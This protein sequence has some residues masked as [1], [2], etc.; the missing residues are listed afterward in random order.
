M[1]NGNVGIGVTAPTAK[2]EVKADTAD[3]S[4]A[5]V[6]MD[7]GD[8]ENFVV[9]DNGDVYSRGQ[10][11]LSQDVSTKGILFVGTGQTVDARTGFSN[12]GVGYRALQG[13]TA[14]SHSTGVGHSALLNASTGSANTAVGRSSFYT[15]TSMTG[16]IA[17]GAYAGYYETGNDKLF[18][19]SLTDAAQV[20]E[21]T[22][23][24]K[25]I[26]Y[27][28]QDGTT[29]ANQTLDLNAQVKATYGLQVGAGTTATAGLIQWDG[30]NFQ[31]YDGSGWVNLDT[32]GDASIWQDSGS[33]TTLVTPRAVQIDAPTAD[34]SAA[35]TI[36]DSGDN[37]NFVV[38]D[39]GQV[40]VGIAIPTEALDVVGNIR[41]S[42]GLLGG[43]VTTAIPLGDVSNTSL[44]IGS[45]FVG[46]INALSTNTLTNTTAISDIIS[47]L[48]T[49]QT[50]AGLNTDG[51]LPAWSS[52]NYLTATTLKAG[53]EELDAAMGS[54]AASTGVAGALQFSDGSGGLSADETNLFWDDTNDRLGIGV[55]IPLSTL[56]INGGVGTFDTGLMFGDGDTG[57]WEDIDDTLHLSI[58]NGASYVWDIT[59]GST[60]FS[61]N[62]NGPGIYHSS[63][64]A[65][66][67]VKF[68]PNWADVDTGI[69]WGG[70]EELVLLLMGEKLGKLQTS[71]LLSSF[72]LILRPHLMERR[73]IRH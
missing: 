4:E 67:T 35:F 72:G 20:D 70:K 15:A 27:G 66:T 50:S 12:V 61:A 45:S 10:N 53:I 41:V 9:R 49:T 37:A 24:T 48:N 32:Q 51:T 42:G 16:G 54:L 7:S 23:R 38:T 17:L 43:V 60:R 25:A 55:A 47:E 71:I 62:N 68:A 31:G 13:S 63:S 14:I 64:T 1:A 36:E 28:V 44:S 3:G 59:A 5:F 39:D 58:G 69:G 33:L 29:T 18:I 11:I 22:A 2:L 52:T 8:T 65:S 46:A 26:I 73:Q 6:V 34:G 57:F 21:A 40:G 19:S 56:H 30:S